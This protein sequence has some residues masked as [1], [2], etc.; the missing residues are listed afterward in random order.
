MLALLMRLKET[1]EQIDISY[2]LWLVYFK[3]E[4]NQQV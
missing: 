4:N 1:L 2:T 3:Q